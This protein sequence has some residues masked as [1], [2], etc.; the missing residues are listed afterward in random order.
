M[1]F[2]A[3]KELLAI[4]AARTPLTSAKNLISSELNDSGGDFWDCGNSDCEQVRDI[5]ADAQDILSEIQEFCR[6]FMAMEPTYPFYRK[7]FEP[8]RLAYWDTRLRL[9]E[10]RIRDVLQASSST[11]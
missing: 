4:T 8:D 7:K 3:N 10:P 5:L 1:P 6:E 2:D 9:L 11:S